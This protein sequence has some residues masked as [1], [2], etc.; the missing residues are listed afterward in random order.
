MKKLIACA[1]AVFW[2]LVA[3]QATAASFPADTITDY[4]EVETITLPK[5]LRGEVGAIDFLPDGRMVACFRRGEVMFYNPKTKVWKLFAE[6]LHDPLG[7]L[8]ISPTE[9]L[10]MQRPELT[11][12]KDTNAD[13][14]ADEYQ[15]AYDDFGLSGNYHEFAFGPVRDRQGNIFISLNL[16]SNGAGI[17][18]EVR[19]KF[20]PLGRNGRMYSTVPYRGWVM[21]L[22]KDGKAIPYALGFRSPNSLGFD[23][24][25]NLWVADNQGD[26]L[27]TSKLY[28]VQEGKFYGQPSSLVWKEGFPDIDPL[29]LPVKTL[30][31]MRTVES[32]AF[33]HSR[34]ANS[35]TQPLLDNTGG[36]FG[37]FAGKMLIGE[38]DHPYLI[39]LM[40]ETVGG[41]MQGACVPFLAGTGLARGNNR[42]AFAPDGSLWV[43]QTDR[44]WVGNQ[45]IQRIRWKGGVPMEVADMK[46]TTTGFDLTFTHPLEASAVQELQNFAFKRYY[47]EYHEAYGSKQFDVQPV[48]VRSAQLSADGRTVSLTLAEL[49]PGYIH[50][51]VLGDLRA[52]TGQKLNSRLVFYTLNRLKKDNQ[53]AEGR[54]NP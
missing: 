42:L 14:V 18:P 31:S 52:R 30:D 21:K 44:G 50:E 38:M 32:I 37:P 2:G 35:P 25:G 46:L 22:T 34:L 6:G 12:L 28:H 10:V 29:K 20:E 36:K 51:L 3:S 5:G 24:Q 7:I 53:T 17:F 16:A 49:K 45:G 41:Q 47:Y 43:G 9:I 13:G 48:P 19:G 54:T 4:Y 1:V 15:V 27:G 33:P 26:W 8:A 23:A 39:R 11:R 40:P